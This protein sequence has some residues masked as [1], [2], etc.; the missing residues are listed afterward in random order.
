MKLL[1]PL[2]FSLLLVRSKYLIADFLY[3][4]FQDDVI[5]KL[6]ERL[7]PSALQVCEDEFQIINMAYY[8][9]TSEPDSGGIRTHIGN[10]AVFK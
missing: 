10:L 1:V 2:F 3:C 8:V 9:R 7:L 4:V 5:S 6:D